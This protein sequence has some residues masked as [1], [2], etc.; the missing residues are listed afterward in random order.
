[1]GSTLT[2]ASTRASRIRPHDC[3]AVFRALAN[4]G[5]V[6]GADC[7]D[8]GEVGLLMLPIGDNEA[9]CSS[10][11][12]AVAFVNQ[13]LDVFI[14]GGNYNY[15]PPQAPYWSTSGSGVIVATTFRAGRGFSWRF[16]ML[17]PTRTFPT[18]ADR[19]N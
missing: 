4:N 15:G 12:V 17:W 18:W 16:R 6:G 14:V 10:A 5:S 1:V 19:P 3:T 13:F 2:C 11:L 9:R 7:S 8:T